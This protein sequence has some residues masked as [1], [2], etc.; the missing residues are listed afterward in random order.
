MGL[1]GPTGLTEIVNLRGVNILSNICEQF[2]FKNKLIAI[3][4]SRCNPTLK[5]SSTEEKAVKNTSCIAVQCDL[6]YK[7]TNKSRSKSLTVELNTKTT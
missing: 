7:G 2:R 4:C 6:R 3:Q 5:S 1:V